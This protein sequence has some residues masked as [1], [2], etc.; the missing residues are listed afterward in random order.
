[1]RQWFAFMTCLCLLAWPALSRA[2]DFDRYTNPVL[3]KA[4]GAEG[5]QELKQLTPEQ[6][7]DNDRV[8]SDATGALVVVRTNQGRY[9]KLLVRPAQR[10]IDANTKLPILS[11]ERYTTYREGEE[12]AIQAHGENLELFDGFRLSLDMGQVVPEAVGGDVRFVVQ[13]EKNYLEPLG[14]AQLFLVTKALP[15]TEPEKASGP[16]AGA[17]FE[18]R[19]FNG[20]YKLYDDGRR[21]GTL[22]LQVGH[23]GDVTGAYYSD[24]DGQKYEVS[25]DSGHPA[26]SI[27]FTIKFPRVEEMFQ[28]W[29]FTGDGKAIAGSS[30]LQDRESGFYAMRVEEKK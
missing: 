7:A 10:K 23:S 14:K 3:A 21:S 11:I 19:F 17:S 8:I 26:H 28:G 4:P 13:G 15:G 5:V 30:K 25:G 16:T 6:M 9:A 22:K 2:D 24:R 20:T 27:R 1:M 29:L 12:R 18:P